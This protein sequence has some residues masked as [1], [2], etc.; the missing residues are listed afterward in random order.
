MVSAHNSSEYSF[1]NARRLEDEIFRDV[2]TA[3]RVIEGASEPTVIQFLLDE[4]EEHSVEKPVDIEHDG[5]RGLGEVRRAIL[6]SDHIDKDLKRDVVSRGD[7]PR[8][9]KTLVPDSVLD[10]AL[11]AL[12]TGKPIVL[13]GPTGTGKTTFAKQLSLQT[14]IGYDI[15]TASPSWT[16]QDIVGRVAPSY[17]ENEI[18]YVKE[19]GCVS[20]AVQRAR[21]FDEKWAVIIDEL[22]RADISRIFGPLYTAIENRDQTIFETEHETIKLDSEVDLICTMNVSDR[23]VNELDNAITR[24]FAMIEI[25]EY[26][27][28][29]REELF[30]SWAGKYLSDTNLDVNNLL[31]LFHEDYERLNFG[32]EE[33]NEGLIEFGPM[34]YEDVATFLGQVCSK[35]TDENIPGLGRYQ[36]RPAEAIGQ[37]FRIYIVPRLLNDATFP[38]I[39]QLAE[40]Y[41]E[42]NEVFESIDLEPAIQLAEQRHHNE[43][44]RM[45]GS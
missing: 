10:N 17:D 34:H 8:S 42:L 26:S 44:Q 11:G 14:C 27:R 25:S 16:D 18:Q 6:R 19:P 20:L 2:S 32:K 37:A 31:N 29:D 40:H 21:E 3:V 23:T 7:D 41:R 4:L 33:T 5:I 12:A 28:E 38:Q 22:T 15:H 24:R 30:D 13:Y 35:T 36:D 1:E 39:K 9:L 43:Q 45:R